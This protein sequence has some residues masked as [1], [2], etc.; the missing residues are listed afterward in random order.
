M[1]PPSGPDRMSREELRA[2]VSLGTLYALR[3]FGMFLILPVFAVHAP[4]LAHGDDLMLVGLALGAYAFTQAVF[5]IPYGMA[6]DRFGRK[7]VIVFG[8]LVFAAGSFIAAASTD[9]YLT[10]LGRC[11]QGAG[12]IAAAVMA[13]AAD[14]TREAHRTKTMAMIGASIGLVFAISL[15]AAPVM[16]RWIGLGGIFALTG[17]L[18]LTG[19]WLTLAAVP[20]EPA[21][22]AAEGL[23][24]GGTALRE[25]LG[26]AELARLNFGIFALHLTQM[27]MF[28]VV[29]LLLVDPGGLAASEH[30][31]VYLPVVLL[32]FVLM[33]PPLLAAERHGRSRRLF[34][35]SIALIGLAQ[36][37]LTWWATGV[38]TIAVLLLAFFVAFNLLEAAI[39][40]LVTRLAPQRAKG[41]ALGVYN[42]TQAMGLFAGG[43]LGGLLAQH[44]GVH[45]VFVACALLMMVWLLVVAWMRVPPPVR[46]HVVAVSA[47]LDPE[48]L[49]RRLVEVPGVRAAVVVPGEGV[50]RLE[51][52]PGWDE[53]RVMNLVNGRA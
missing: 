5:Q 13:L 28:V 53:P 7:R 33:I 6:A 34:A 12:A 15:V 14:L 43:A 8:L 20:A 3:M 1:V 16:Y 37:G 24:L 42:T 21:A 35:G 41:T 31:K 4:S 11:V 23:D 38:A 40:S 26:N 10:I 27:A 46:T 36:L 48:E 22:R 52:V 9:I 50:A 32:S 29:P 44:L 25:V 39:P 30:W 45:A 18:A 17:V 19:V 49:R 2:G 51:V 47:G